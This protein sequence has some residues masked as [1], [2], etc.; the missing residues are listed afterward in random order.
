MRCDNPEVWDGVGSGRE[1]QEE[2]THT[3][4]W[5]IHIFVWQKPTH[6]KA[7]ILQ[8]KIFKKKLGFKNHVLFGYI[9]LTT[10]ITRQKAYHKLTYRRRTLSISRTTIIISYM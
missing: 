5:L 8:L 3:Y 1:V 7:I 9:L 6:C 4:L 2:G 10:P